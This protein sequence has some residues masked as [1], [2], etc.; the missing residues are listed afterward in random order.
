[1]AKRI[2][3]K[4]PLYSPLDRDAIVAATGPAANRAPSPAALRTATVRTKV[5]RVEKRR[6]LH[7]VSRLG[8]ALDASVSPSHLLRPL[9]ELVIEAE[10][11]LLDIAR[12]GGRIYRPP[13]DRRAEVDSFERHIRTL[14]LQALSKKQAG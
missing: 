6:F 8:E 1:M 13:N 5:T 12:S 3:V 2:N 7:L 9:M 4:E 10:R 11:P 14:I